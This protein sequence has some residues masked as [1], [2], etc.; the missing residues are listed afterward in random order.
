MTEDSIE[1][2]VEIERQLLDLYRE[3]AALRDF[4]DETPEPDEKFDELIA[5]LK[6]AA[7]KTIDNVRY[8]IAHKDRSNT[9]EA[10]LILLLA[11]G[12]AGEVRASENA[13]KNNPSEPRQTYYT[14]GPSDDLPR[15]D[16]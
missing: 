12:F 4:E 16:L 5:R 1:T 9:D 6:S 13:R 14:R 11:L 15:K 8:L 3:L 10:S 7:L 2:I